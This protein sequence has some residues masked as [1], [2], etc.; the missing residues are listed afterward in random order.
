[1][2][3]P[4]DASDSGSD[5]EVEF[6]KTEGDDDRR[7]TLLDSVQAGDESLDQ[8]KG[9]SKLADYVGFFHLPGSQ[10]AANKPPTVRDPR[11]VESTNVPPPT[12]SSEVIDLSLSTDDE[13][14]DDHTGGDVIATTSPGPGVECD[15]QR[16]ITSTTSVT[17]KS[18]DRSPDG[19]WACPICTLYAPR[20]PLL[21]PS[22]PSPR[23]SHLP[24]SIP[25]LFLSPPFSIS[26]KRFSQ[27]EP[28]QT[29]QLR[30]LW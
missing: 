21:L 4:D 27:G 16:T 18:P 28:A 12:T 20:P 19:K 8:L 17:G 29:S 22:S 5:E 9:Q 11:R 6:V 7:K 15:I 2:Q 26:T 1:M 25:F 13:G 10:D 14:D 24:A 23:P 3:T 30:S